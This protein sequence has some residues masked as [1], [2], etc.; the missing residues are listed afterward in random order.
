MSRAVV[1]AYHEVGYRCL[2]VLL[3]HGVDVLLVLTH[4]DDAGENIWFPSVAELAAE[5]ELPCEAPDDVATAR[6]QE[7]V[8]ALAPDFIFSF[9][10]RRMLPMALLATASRGAY[11]MHG[12]LLPA[13][14]GRVPVNWA[15]INGERET[16]ATLHGMVEKPDA[17]PIVAQQRVPIF[18][19][20]TAGEVFRK[21]TVA[22]ELALDAVLPSLLAGSATH[23]PQDLSLGSYYGGRKPGDGRIDW[24]E[25]AEQIHNL[26]RGVAPPYPGA[27]T[28]IAGKRLRVLR[29][30]PLPNE[31]PRKL[32]PALEI[33]DG[34]IVARCGDGGSLWLLDLEFDDLKIDAGNFSGIF[35]SAVVP[36][37]QGA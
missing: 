6:M 12:S 10:Y 35:G 7:R 25:S 29:S 11:N 22:A 2:S 1:F 9:Y 13:Y 24:G 18:P 19:D 3:A 8:A 31:K 17:G 20:D 23:V 30:K 14:R 37:G 21:V 28:T 32:R 4:E 16:G 33:S 27:F 34:R 36:L 15:V 5:N 26:V